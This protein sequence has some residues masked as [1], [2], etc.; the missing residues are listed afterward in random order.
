V[1]QCVKSGKSVAHTHLRYLNPFPKN[2]GEIIKRYDKVLI[3]ELNV[4]QL[5]MLIRGTYLADAVG[6][7]KIQGK[8]F[9]VSEIVRKIDEL[10]GT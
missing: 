10:L 5:R 7:N 2:L 8:P 4:G 1:Q 3:P 9:L 6:L